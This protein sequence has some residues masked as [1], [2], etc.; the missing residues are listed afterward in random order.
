MIAFTFPGQGA[1]K[2]GMGQ[3]WQHHE[4][5]EL[6]EQA[7]EISGRDVAALLLTADDEELRNTRNAQL[8]TFTLSALMGRAVAEAGLTAAAFAGHSLGEYT[9]L[10]AAGAMEFA[11]AVR[12]VTERG[13][14][15]QVAAEANDGTMAAI[16]GLEDEKVQAVTEPIDDL[17]VA[18]YNAP[19]QVVIAGGRDAIATGS[20]AAKEAGAKRAMALS[21]GGAFHSPHMSPAQERLDAA[22]SSTTLHDPTAPVWSNV[23]AGAHRSGEELRALLAQQLTS[24]VRWSHSVADMVAN[25]VGTLIEIGPGAALTG[26]AKRITKDTTNLKINTPDDVPS[27]IEAIAAKGTST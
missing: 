3:P 11:D 8:A 13:E 6:V 25:G 4:A 26:M 10:T 23:D 27:V 5:W 19:G 7:S 24:P 20:E 21:V 9:A 14:A 22:L 2:S 17:W 18:N 16:L 12:L 15:M 1:Q